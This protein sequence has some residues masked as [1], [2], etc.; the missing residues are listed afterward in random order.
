[1][2]WHG[3][4][5]RAA[6][7]HPMA[8]PSLSILNKFMTVW[9]SVTVPFSCLNMYISIFILR[10]FALPWSSQLS[11]SCACSSQHYWCVAVRDPTWLCGWWR[12]CRGALAR[13][14]AS[15]K[16]GSSAPSCTR[17]CESSLKLSLLWRSFVR[18]R[19]WLCR[20]LGSYRTFCGAIDQGRMDRL[21]ERVLGKPSPQSRHA[22]SGWRLFAS[23]CGWWGCH[24]GQCSWRRRTRMASSS[25][26]S[27]R[28]LDHTNYRKQKQEALHLRWFNSTNKMKR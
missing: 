12:T 5:G 7:G 27:W 26:R 28:N 13:S 11:W 19:F 6:M 18:R 3:S 14:T 10:W 2:A 9:R 21:C 15:S 22:G 20:G 8:L 24:C 17:S 23:R 1:M 16:G 25:S 4:W